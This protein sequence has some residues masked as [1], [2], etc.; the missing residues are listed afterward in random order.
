MMKHYSVFLSLLA[1]ST[2]LWAQNG[3]NLAFNGD[4]RQTAFGHAYGWICPPAPYTTY[5]ETG[6]PDGLPYV[7]MRQGDDDTYENKLRMKYITL[8]PGE[9]YRISA[10]IRTKDFSAR[11]GELLLVN[12]PWYKE[13]G[14]KKFPATT[15]G[16]QKF[17]KEVVCPEKDSGGD[18]DVVLLIIGQ[19][20]E[21]DVADIRLTALSEA[22]AK[23]SRS[24]AEIIVNK[25][26]LIPWGRSFNEIPADKPEIEFVWY[27]R[28]DENF[29][30]DDY[31]VEAKNADGSFT[32]QHVSFEVGKPFSLNLKGL[33]AGKHQLAVR[34][35]SKTDDKIAYEET[36]AA[37]IRNLPQPKEVT[38]GVRLNNLAVEL[39]NKS[40]AVGE[41]VSFTLEHDGWIY[42]TIKDIVGNAA[43]GVTLDGQAVSVDT[44][45][46]LPE[47]F[48][49]LEAGTHV[50]TAGC[51]GRLVIRSIAELFSCG[52]VQGPDIA[53]FPPFDWEFT[54]KYALNTVTTLNR[55]SYVKNG[56]EMAD[57][58]H[59]NGRIWLE[60]MY[61][62]HNKDPESMSNFMERVMA[63]LD[64]RDGNT[65]NEMS[66]WWNLLETYTTVLK[67]FKYNHS[68][69]IY[70]WIGDN[71]PFIPSMHQDFIGTSFNAG[72]GRGKILCESYN[73]TQ[74][75]EEGA[76]KHV[77]SRLLPYI[78]ESC[79]YYPDYLR[80]SGVILGNFNQLNVITIEH[81][82]QVDFKYYL[83]MQMNILANH[84]A[85]EGLGT[86]GYWGTHYADEELY[87]WSH[88]LL[89]HY[90]VEGR[91]DMLSN[92]FGF[93][94]IPGHIVNGDFTEGLSGWTAA[95]A[96]EGAITVEKF[97][98][99]AKRNQNRWNAP[100][101]CGDTFCVFKA[102][103]GKPNKLSQTAKGLT[104]G[105]PYML[106]FSVGDYDELKQQKLNPRRLGLEAILENAEI[107]PESIVYV[108]A[109]EKGKYAHNH[110]VARQNL[111]RILFV[112]KASEMT[113]TF[114][115]EKAKP[116][117]NLMVNY[118]QLKPFYAKEQ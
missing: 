106:L 48:R 7:A 55:G 28:M 24:A 29:K 45:T 82:P 75:T 4:F 51:A 61:V 85:F 35:V 42:L 113:V 26:R 69:L 54:K 57:A 97:N 1:M 116:G 27:G 40:V 107:L 80:R 33:P 60:D 9:R 6:G 67:R 117:E 13:A 102:V 38:K 71:A 100:R 34:I 77:L 68:K 47:A 64:F 88:A 78:E 59:A 49:L 79:Q 12:N 65:T 98:G 32:T 58:V 72:D 70:T 20:G 63:K 10:W 30:T 23:D 14:I 44:L 94:Y 111:H 16:W 41:K 15:D 84:P 52:M 22:A 21:L 109:R 11:R 110:N 95:P 83:D 66:Y 8:V 74:T 18:Y 101:G 81:H 3:D 46:N 99:Y 31:L 62:V 115:D 43:F 108:D 92:Q 104:A 19:R 86:V 53:V 105:R 114:T 56:K 36:F 103:E 118:I 91:K 17:E 96:T 5:H 76:Y 50:V 93:H 39:V 73:Y 89:R 37:T 112:P 90:V 25:P 87:R 2:G